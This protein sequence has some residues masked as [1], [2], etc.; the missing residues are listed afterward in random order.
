MKDIKSLEEA[1]ELSVNDF[2][3][4]MHTDIE[5]FSQS[6]E[7]EYL[8]KNDMDEISRQTFYALNDFKK[9]IISYLKDTTN[10]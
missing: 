10:K 3:K 4:Q 6:H 9:H 8:N 2:S 7:N 5:T 1:L